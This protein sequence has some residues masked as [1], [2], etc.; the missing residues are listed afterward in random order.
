MTARLLSSPTERATKLQEKEDNTAANLSVM[1]KMAGN[2]RT[3][4]LLQKVLG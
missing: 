1:S 3:E 2:Q 4:D